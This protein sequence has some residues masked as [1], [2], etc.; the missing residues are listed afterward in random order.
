MN[1]DFSKYNGKDTVLRK[2]QL[3]L[4]E[5]FI[6]VDKICKKHNIP[7]WIDGGTTL[8]AVR[9]G[10]FIPWDDDVDIALLRKDYLRLIKVLEQELPENL[11]L[12]NHKNEKHFHMLYSRVVDKNSIADYGDFSAQFR[13]HFKH[14]GLFLDIFYIDRGNLSLKRFVD[15]FYLTSFRIIRKHNKRGNNKLIL[16]MGHI[17]WV[18]SCLLVSFL[19]F[20]SFLFPA[21]KLIYGYGIPY[22]WEFRKSEILPEKPIKFE[23]VNVYGPKDTH[24]YLKRC[25]GN[26]MELPP[27]DQRPTHA[28][29]IKI[30]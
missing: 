15:F 3:R 1:E 6:E 29:R 11:A 26:Y 14:K 20:M 8:G 17:V 9:H 13:N 22:N 28:E 27:V 2:A 12:Q 10:G 5:I 19:R 18:L 30:Y 4:L 25:F 7:Y 16:F 24:A 23:G 21:D